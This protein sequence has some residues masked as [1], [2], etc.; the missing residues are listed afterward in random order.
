MPAGVRF[1]VCASALAAAAAAAVIDARSPIQP[2]A[3][4]VIAAKL[5]FVPP[6]EALACLRSFPFNE[7]IRQNVRVRVPMRAP[8]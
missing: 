1:L 8:R 4:K 7:T 2:D 5:P 3:C 6:E